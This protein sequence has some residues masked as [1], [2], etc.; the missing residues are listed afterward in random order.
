[1]QAVIHPVKNQS[2]ELSEAVWSLFE[3][4]VLGEICKSCEREE[5]SG[6]HEL[7]NNIVYYYTSEFYT[8]LLQDNMVFRHKTSA[9]I[10]NNIKYNTAHSFT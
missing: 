8:Q 10:H 6:I 5:V 3:K 1:M 4:I 9:Q 7:Y 2:E